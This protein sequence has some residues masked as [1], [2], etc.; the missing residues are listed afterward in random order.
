MSVEKGKLVNNL[1]SYY[2]SGISNFKN[3]VYAVNIVLFDYFADLFFSGDATRIVYSSTDYAL[4]KRAKKQ[5]SNNLNFPFMNMQIDSSGLVGVETDRPWFN[6]SAYIDGIYS[7]ELQ[8]KIKAMPLK[9]KYDATLFLHQDIEAQY[10]MYK[11]IWQD[12][13]ETKIEPT[14]AIGDHTVKLIG[15]LGYPGLDFN[16]QYTRNDWLEQNKVFTINLGFEVDTFYIDTNEDVTLTED[17]I[18]NFED[19]TGNND[20]IEETFNINF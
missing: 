1:N 19:K 12:A 10:T 4:R 3:T 14:I 2:S 7:P 5:A 9:L 16:P 13:K 15:T 6:H 17:T 18:L 20:G 8:Y 11:L